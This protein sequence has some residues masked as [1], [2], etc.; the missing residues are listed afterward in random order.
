MPRS[1]PT[2]LRISVLTVMA[3]LLGIASP[4]LA[5]QS[6]MDEL[7]EAHNTVIAVDFTELR[8]S[9]LF[10]EGFEMV[11]GQP[12]A[13]A[14]LRQVEEDFGLD[15]ESDIAALVVASDSPPLSSQLVS[16]PMAALENPEQH[17]ASGALVL[18]RGD[19]D[20]SDIIAEMADLEEDQEAPSQIRQ[21]G[22]EVGGI[23]DQTLA[24]STGDES[25]LDESRRQLAD[26]RSGPGAAF[27][28]GI[29][30]LGGSQGLY[31]MT[32]PTIPDPEA[33]R[34][35]VGAVASFGGMSMD[36]SDEVR[37]SGLVTLGG[38]EEAEEMVE[39]VDEIR[40]EVSGN[41]LVSLFG[42]APLV[43]NLS[44]RQD[45]NEVLVRTSMTNHEASR[46]V[47]QLR[48]LVQ[49]QQGLQNPLQG[50]GFGGDSDDDEDE[51]E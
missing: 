23:D 39:Q 18:I 5:G 36:L 38:E 50:P 6:L 25:F 28:R 21:P 48:S 30:R 40:N 32:Q 41:P 20:A 24:I 44:V 46:L 34:D 10:E 49:S 12:A 35:E 42:V 19:L 13:A 31:M 27:T 29:E 22:F 45:D 3:T 16:N 26:D 1:I 51:D 33:M 47:S 2:T 7:P 43:D 14:A 9:P 17:Q 15:I 11:K 37:I 8:D 4:A